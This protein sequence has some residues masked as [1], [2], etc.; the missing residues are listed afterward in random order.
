MQAM[1]TFS[2][3][4][5]SAWLAG[6]SVVLALGASQSLANVVTSNDP[7]CEGGATAR[8]FS[9]SAVTVSNC[10]LKG[11]G[12][13]NGNGDAINGLGWTTL[14]KSDDGT[15]GVLE[16]ALSITGGNDWR[17]LLSIL[18]SAYTD[19]EFLVVA[20]KSGVGQ[21][22][23]DWAGFLLADNTLTGVGPLPRNKQ[24]RCRT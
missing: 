21:F 19:Y 14:D 5:K 12:N 16:G 11:V 3:A 18:A 7:N 2:V 20:L 9:V 15:T 22:D 17:Y 1:K 10:L 13:I 24:V 6:V 4:R 8:V 23:P